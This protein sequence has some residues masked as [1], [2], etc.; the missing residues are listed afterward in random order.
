[1]K[2]GNKTCLIQLKDQN[3]KKEVM[4]NKSKL[5]TKMGNKIFI[6]DGLSKKYREI[7]KQIR[8]R[9]KTGKNIEH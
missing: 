1:M 7:M 5:R 3:Q 8:Y 9:A 4:K 2:L 6:Q